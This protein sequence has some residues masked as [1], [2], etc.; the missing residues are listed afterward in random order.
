MTQCFASKRLI[1]SGIFLIM[2]SMKNMNDTTW[3]LKPSERKHS[4]RPILFSGPMV[5]AILDGTKTQ[6]RRALKVQPIDVIPAPKVGGWI[7]LMQREPEPK[8][9][10][11][12]CKYGKPGDHLWVREAWRK[13]PGGLVHYRA[14][15]NSCDDVAAKWKPSIHMFRAD[16]R[17]TLEITS[18]RVERLQDISEQDAWKEGCE[19]SDDDVTGGISGYREYCK[20]WESINWPG[21]WDENPW[22]WVVEFKRVTT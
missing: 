20:L 11:F 22:V 10:L 6:T 5:L 2:R 8:G 16:S 13:E 12:H 7:G 9:L 1:Y 3:Q 4:E 15:G 21:S 19:G 17:I 18:V 14:D